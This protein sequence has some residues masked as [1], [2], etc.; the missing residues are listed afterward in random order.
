M[1]HGKKVNHLS[2]KAPHRKA[3]LKNLASALIEHK[4][5]TTTTAKAKALRVYIEPLLTK[6]KNN[7]T[8]SRRVVFSYLQSKEAVAELFDNIG[9]KI[10][11]R[12]GG[13]TR[14]IKLAPRLGDGAEMALIELVDYNE[15]LLTETKKSTGKKRRTR[16]GGKSGATEK[17]AEDTNKEEKPKAAAK[18][19]TQ[20]EVKEEIA[21]TPVVEDA[22]VEETQVEETQVEETQV[23]ETAEAETKEEAPAKEDETKQEEPEAKAEDTEEDKDKA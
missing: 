10:A 14:I 1:R 4:R 20:E 8:H 22:Q 16:R 15:N 7:T 9:G 18:E 2:R 12:P 3:L 23:E 21:E 11:N 13:Y 17:K 6:A 19:T 5:I